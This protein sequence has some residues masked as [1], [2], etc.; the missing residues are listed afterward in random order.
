MISRRRQIVEGKNVGVSHAQG[1]EA[2]DARHLLQIV[3][4]RVGVLVNQAKSSK[5]E[6]KRHRGR[7]AESVEGTPTC[8]RKA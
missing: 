1:F 2:E 5:V 8:W 7:G 3:E 6:G 4:M